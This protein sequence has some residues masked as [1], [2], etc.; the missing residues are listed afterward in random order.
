MKNRPNEIQQGGCLNTLRYSV[1]QGS[2]FLALILTKAYVSA[3]LS[4][5]ER[6]DWYIYEIMVNKFIFKI[7]NLST[8]GL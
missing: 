7:K 2:N 5:R 4:N 6:I 8:E 1:N 3:L